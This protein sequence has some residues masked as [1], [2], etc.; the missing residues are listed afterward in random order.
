[1]IATFGDLDVSRAGAARQ[2]TRSA[3]IVK[4]IGQVANGAIPGV[5]R[6]AAGA[7]ASVAFGPR[8]QNRKWRLLRTG[9]QSGSG[10]NTFQF[11]STHHRIDFR[12]IFLDLV[13]IT[14]NQTAGDDQFPSAARVF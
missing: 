10:K 11:T 1:M 6:K 12:N 3:L 4:V 7:L 5:A 2:N 13:A 8:I 14:L 9:I